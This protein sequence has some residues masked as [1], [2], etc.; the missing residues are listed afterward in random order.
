[1]IMHLL[2]TLLMD[3][4]HNAKWRCATVL[5]ALL[6]TAGCANGPGATLSAADLPPLQL[7]DRTIPPGLAASAAPT[8][9][10]LAINDEMRAFVQ[11][12]T[13]GVGNSHQRLMMLHRAVSG[14]GVLNIDYDPL[15]EGTAI[16]VFNRG[17]ANCLSYAHLFVA[18]AREAGLDA[19]YQWLEVRPQWTRQGERVMVRLHVNVSVTLRQGQQFMVDIDPLPAS[20]ITGSQGI[21]DS[22]A[23]AL[24]HN[25]IAMQALAAEQLEQAWLHALRAVQLSPREP[26][27]WINIGAIYRMAGQH[28]AAESSYMNAL[29]L[30]PWDRSAMNNLVVLYDIEGR[31]DDRDYWESRVAQYRDNNPFYHA[32]L[33]DQA[34]ERDDWPA[35]LG[36]Y[37]DALGLLP[38]DSRLLYSAGMIHYQL[39]QW[40]EAKGYLQRALE[41]ATLRSEIE[42]YRVQLDAV[43][44]AMLVAAGGAAD[45]SQPG[46]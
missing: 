27:L 3:H 1:M 35:A 12:Y 24:Y 15:A 8:P 7:D 10:L 5:L 16:E 40:R 30:D 34:G 45:L 37:E 22:D 42:S 28:R 23:A 18:L 32:W 2:P 21:S 17:T 6:V 13:G 46:S 33:G 19:N 11:R 25:N 41:T 39:A 43:N 14:S 29:A 38:Q 26:Y 9:D 20:D 44:R 31:T 4:W 36:H